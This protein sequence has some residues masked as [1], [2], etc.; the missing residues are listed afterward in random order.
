[1]ESVGLQGTFKNTIYQ[2]HLIG[3]PRNGEIINSPRYYY[4]LEFPDGCVYEAKPPCDFEDVGA[5]WLDDG[6]RR[7]DLF[8]SEE[9][10]EVE[11]GFIVVS[12]Q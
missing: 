3:G 4:R 9:E 8:F 12:G 7:V 11:I 2:I 1:M 5:A 6:T 10:S